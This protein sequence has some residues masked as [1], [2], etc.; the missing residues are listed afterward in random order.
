MSTTRKPT[1]IVAFVFKPLF[2]KGRWFIWVL[3]FL[4]SMMMGN[5]ITAIRMEIP[6]PEQVN[7]VTGKFIDTGKG[8]SKTG[9]FP[10]AIVDAS[11]ITHRCNCEPLGYSNCLGRRPSDHTELLNQLDAEVVKK[12]TMHKAI[13]KWLDGRDGE[14]WMY[15]NRSI[16]GTKNSCYK[17]SSNGYTLLSFEQ[18]VQNY[19]KAKSGVDIYLFWFVALSGLFAISVYVIVRINTYLKEIKNG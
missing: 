18:S 9:L 19:E 17:I 15:P 3:F 5:T 7:R 12:Y 8:Y 13:L 2:I 6:K 16:F 1:G 4:M 10:I 11:G 14:V